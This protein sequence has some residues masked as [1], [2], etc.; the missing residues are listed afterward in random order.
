[1]A[2]EIDGSSHNDKQ[3]YDKNRDIVAAAAGITTIRFSEDSVIN[4]I[5]DVLLQIKNVLFSS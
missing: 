4:N 3:K 1:M 2:F 5:N